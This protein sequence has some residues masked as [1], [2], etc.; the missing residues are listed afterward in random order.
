MGHSTEI[1]EI[2]DLLKHCSRNL[3]NIS[4]KFTII[5]AHRMNSMHMKIVKFAALFPEYF[6]LS[7]MSS[8][9]LNTKSSWSVPDHKRRLIY[10][11][12]KNEKGSISTDRI[13]KIAYVIK[14]TVSSGQFFQFLRPGQCF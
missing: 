8:S 4:G 5:A 2:N 14:D 12:F 11:A 7:T 9:I 10:F 3:L 1:I 13:L 6:G